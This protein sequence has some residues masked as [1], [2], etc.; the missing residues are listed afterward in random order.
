MDLFCFCCY[1]ISLQ[2]WYVLFTH[3]I[4][5]YFIGRRVISGVNEVTLNDIGKSPESETQQNTTDW[6]LC[7]YFVGCT[8]RYTFPGGTLCMGSTN[9]RR[10]YNVTSSLI[11]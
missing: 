6:E 5:D 3:I 9:E 11:G 8:V 2:A 10:R 7:A 1:V 4:Q